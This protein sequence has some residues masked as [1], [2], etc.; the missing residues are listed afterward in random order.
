[1]EGV[2]KKLKAY[3]TIYGKTPTIALAKDA[4]DS[5]VKEN[6]NS[7]IT[8]DFIIEQ[9]A[10]YHNITVDQIKGSQRDATIVKPRQQAMYLIRE[11]TQLSLPEIG[12]ATGGKNHTT[13]LHA[14][15]VVGEGIKK[16]PSIAKTIAE[17]TE[18]I[19]KSY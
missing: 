15:K 11:L 19:K 6:T 12:N 7:A 9:V 13:V 16:D 14:T 10:K 8:P 4:M 3:N 2:I 1:M 17:L 18:N 5:I